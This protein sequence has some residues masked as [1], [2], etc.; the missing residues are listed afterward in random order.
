M[1]RGCTGCNRSLLRSFCVRAHTRT[2][3][4]YSFTN[5][6]FLN[7]ADHAAHHS[8]T[9][10]PGQVNVTQAEFEAIALAQVQCDGGLACS[11]AW[12]MR[13]GGG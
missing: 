6:F 8:P 2:S 12:E 9:V 11:R 10:L 5:N 7:V 3:T 13:G 1:Q 4:Y